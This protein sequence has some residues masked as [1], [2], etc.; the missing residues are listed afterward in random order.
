MISR[1]LVGRIFR[2]PQALAAK[3]WFDFTFRN[4]R[5]EQPH[6]KTVRSFNIPDDAHELTFSCFRRLS[7][8]SRDRTRSWLFNAFETTR[9]RGNLALW[10]YVIMP[11]HVHVIVYPRDPAGWHV[12]SP[13]R[14]FLFGR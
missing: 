6:P 14:F 10:A 4:A 7:L 3:A 1:P 5:Q 9:Q 12:V 8:L 13:R 2:N 11:E